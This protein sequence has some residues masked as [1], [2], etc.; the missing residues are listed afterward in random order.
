MITFPRKKEKRRKEHRESIQSK[1][2]ER[3]EVEIQE[4][5]ERS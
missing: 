3:G 4:L 2:A 5:P 1:E